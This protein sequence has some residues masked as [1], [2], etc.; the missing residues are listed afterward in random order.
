[1]SAKATDSRPSWEVFLQCV[2]TVSTVFVISELTDH[3]SQALYCFVSGEDVFV[4][5]PTGYGKSLIFHMAPLVH[6]WMHQNVS[7]DLWAK[8]PILLVISPL[9]ALMQDQVKK[10][11]S[12]GLKAAYVGAEQ[13]PG[14][15]RDIEEG[16]YSFV[17]ISPES[18]LSTERWRNV[19][20]SDKYQRDVIGVAV[21][22]VHCIAEWGTSTSNKNRSSFRAWYSR[23]NEIRS[24]LEVPFIALTAT[25]TVKTK[26]Q[27]YELLEFGSPKEIVESPNKFNVRYSVQKLE[28]SLS[29][30]ENFRCLIN[31][32]LNKGKESVRTI[33]YCQTI[34]QCSH[35]FRM[36]E[37]ELGP[38]FFW[39]ERNPRNRLVEMM[40]SGSPVSV[41]DHVLSQF[42]DDSTCLRV[43]IATI[44]YGMGVNCKGVKRVIHFGPSKTIQAYM[45]ESGRCGRNGEQSDALLLY[46]GITIK[47]ADSA[48][49]SYV[50]SVRCR[51]NFLLEQFGVPVSQ[52]DFP[53]GHMCCDN[54]ADSCKCQ[55]GYCNIDLHLPTL[56]DDTDAGHSREISCEQMSKLKD[57]LKVLRRQIVRNTSDA[58]EQNGAS[59]SGCGTKLLEF[60]TEQVQQVIQNA[61]H[62]FSLA[63]LNK[64]VDIW[65]KKHANSVMTIFQSIFN[66]VKEPV[67]CTSEEDSY[68]EDNGDE[69]VKLMDDQSFMEL[70]DLSEWDVESSIEDESI[71]DMHDDSAYPEFLDSVICNLNID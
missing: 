62:I 22:E 15:L 28:N 12:V 21:D 36:F 61:N 67:N 49:K 1:M 53:A 6:T 3:Q 64:H 27:I 31:E 52:S 47:A 63:D 57:S 34:K 26:E 30:V 68:F 70:L 46:N 59:L 4:N 55:G 8:E 24:L 37:L 50:K 38:S 48:M 54:C 16:K 23:L 66:D 65:Q 71:S 13:E 32:L 5:L 39:G 18:T 56:Q 42:S 41:K 45:Q 44:A 9:L 25:A 43:L 14:T 29:I 33:I 35:I 51:R 11:K 69:W 10:L 60:G 19:L 40:H 17:F 58:L 2:R 20:L 7:P